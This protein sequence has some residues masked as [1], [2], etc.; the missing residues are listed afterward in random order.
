MSDHKNLILTASIV[1]ILLVACLPETQDPTQVVPDV[2]VLPNVV[3]ATGVVVPAREALLSVSAGGNI[4]DLLV[5]Q[6]DP[7]NTGELLVKLEGSEAQVAAVSAAELEL[8]NARIALE[9]LYKD[10]D[11][12]A[13]E[14]LKSAEAAEQALEDLTN[15]ELQQA[16]ARQAVADAQKVL[17]VAERNLLILTKP[18]T[19]MVI[20]EAR[21]NLRLAEKKHEETLDQIDDLQWQYKKYSSNKT[22]PAK[23]RAN[24]LTQIK[25]ALK[26]IEVQRTQE[27]RNLENMRSRLDDLLAPPDP[28]DIQVAE[29]EL[30][31]AQALLNDADRELKRIMDGPQPGEVALLEAQINKGL[32]DFEIYRNGPDPQDIALAEARIKNAEAQLEAARAM[33][34]DQQLLAPFNGVITAVHVNPGEWIAPGSPVLQVGD[35]NQLQIETTDLSEFDVAKL[36]IG[37]PAVITFDSLPDVNIQG[38]VARIAPKS[39]DGSGVNF[40]VVIQLEKIPATLRWGMTAFVDITPE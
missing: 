35:L 28:V 37:D 38:S 33:I 22:L 32:Q 19:K 3:S 9:A 11:L 36:D 18:A 24:I 7:V 20:E 12:L 6:G 25:Q 23:I 27:Q 2:E 30:A 31:T 21:G 26:V 4:S 16:Q 17:D 10:T 34:A 1:I 39:E 40:P 8:L 14:S 29:A 13:A 5:E 15:N